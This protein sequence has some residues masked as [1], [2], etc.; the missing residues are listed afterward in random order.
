[1]RLKDK[2]ILAKCCRPSR[3]D[4]IRGYYSHENFIKVHR[5]DC[6]SLGKIDSERLVDLDWIEILSKA[7]FKPGEDYYQL[8][9]IDFKILNHHRQLGLDYSLKVARVISI[10]KQTVFDRHEKLRQMG[11]LERVEARIIRYRKNIVPGKW[12]KHRNHTYYDLTY[13]GNNYLDF[14]LG[15]M[16][17]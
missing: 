17:K 12:I 1:M 2:Y 8:D 13:H 5:T 6:P 9:E 7:S 3:S 15:R 14:Y 11:L 16:G 4:A 10:D